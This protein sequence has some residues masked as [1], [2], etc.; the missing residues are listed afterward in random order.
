MDSRLKKHPLGYW[1]IENKPTQE[2]LQKYY[3]EKYYQEGEGSYE[4]TY[5]EEELSYFNAKLEQRFFQF[6]SVTCK[7]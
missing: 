7:L 2:E 6:S 1:E 5:S 3:A 4:L